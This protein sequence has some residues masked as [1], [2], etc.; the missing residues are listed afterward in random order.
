[1][2]LFLASLSALAFGGA[3]F[4]GGLAS[5]RAP[6]VSVVVT[7]HAIGLVLV[8]AVAPWWG[9]SGVAAPDVLW[10]AAAG[11]SGA[12]GLVILYHGLA[13]TRFSVVAPAAAVVGAVLPVA[14]GLAIG[15]RPEALAWAGVALALPAILLVSSAGGGS[16]GDARRLR[17]AVLLG[18][19]AGALFGLFGI[20]ISR[21]ADTSG[22]WPLVGARAASLPTV[23]LLA[24]VLGKPLSAPAPVRPVALAAGAADMIANI[25]LL[26]ALHEPGLLALVLLVS[27]LY[28]A[29]TVVLARAVLDERMTRLQMAGLV[30][31]GA[32]LA[33]IAVA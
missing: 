9:S 21:S 17:R 16:G 26:G 3:D 5:R 14:F 22:L 31:A 27:S 28:P 8:G 10:G 15:E 33:L 25:L 23:G 4:V 7:G 19:A 11:A 24:L 32:G 2:A 6:S 18:A 30:L 12:F 13:T 29:V 20:F 1:M